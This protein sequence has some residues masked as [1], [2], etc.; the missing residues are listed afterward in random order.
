MGGTGAGARDVAPSGAVTD[1]LAG[2]CGSCG[3]FHSVRMDPARGV[4]VGECAYG[5]WPAVRPETSSCPAFV[6]AGTLSR[7]GPAAPVESTRRR[8]QSLPT[9]PAPTPHRAPIEIEVDMDEATFRTVLREILR[10]ELG[11]TEAPLAERY[12]GGELVLRP[13][14]AGV[15]DKKFPIETFF[16]KIVML[17]DRLRLLEQRINSNTKLA[18]DEKVALQQYITGCYGSLTTFNVLFRDDDD[19]FQGASGDKE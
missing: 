5:T 14:R 13:G 8:A 19:R 16:H 2:R 7:H 1:A 11:I 12:R 9:A 17:R 10:D 3:Y 4:N 6:P 18:D 15:Q